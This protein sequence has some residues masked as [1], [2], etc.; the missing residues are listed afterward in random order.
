[1]FIQKP[2]F[3]SPPPLVCTFIVYA[4][5]SVDLAKLAGRT[6]AA[7]CNESVKRRKR[8]L[9]MV[10]LCRF[11]PWICAICMQDK[12]KTLFDFLLGS[13]FAGTACPASAG[14]RVAELVAVQTFL[15]QQNAACFNGKVKD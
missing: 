5:A 14:S 10:E 3:R 4:W 1:M 11:G 9:E 6:L 15:F 12:Q 2:L 8:W 7:L 13:S